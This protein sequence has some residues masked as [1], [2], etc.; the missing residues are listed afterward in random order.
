MLIVFS[1]GMLGKKDSTSRLPI[2]NS[3]SCSIISLAKANTPFTLYSS[4]V[5]DFKI[6][7]RNFANLLVGV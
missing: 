2:T 1:I 6:G 3:G 5:K 4:L 7:T